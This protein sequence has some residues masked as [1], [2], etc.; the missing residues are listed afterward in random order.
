[1][2]DII[3]PIYNAFEMTVQCINSILENTEKDSYR[4]ILINDKSTNRINDYIKQF[5]G[6]ENGNI[7]INNETNLGFVKSA[8]IGMKISENDVILLNS[9]TEVTDNWL[10]KIKV[11]CAY[12]DDNCNCNTA[13]K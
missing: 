2:I 11:A 9:D 3:I 7:V 13:Y 8:N 1:M 5:D 6:D 4:L 12:R 10:N